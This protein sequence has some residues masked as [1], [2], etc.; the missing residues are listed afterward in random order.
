MPTKC[1]IYIMQLGADP[2]LRSIRLII[3]CPD[4]DRSTIQL[5]SLPDTIKI[6]HIDAAPERQVIS[7]SIAVIKS[8]LLECGYRLDRRRSVLHIVFDSCGFYEPAQA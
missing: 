6:V 8:S 1:V 3:C 5:S 2:H 7:P 4:S